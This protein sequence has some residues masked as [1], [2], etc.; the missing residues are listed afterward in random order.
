MLTL[1]SGIPV[2]IATIAPLAAVVL[3]GVA[4]IALHRRKLRDAASVWA[5]RTPM[6]D[7]DFLRAC[8]VPDEPFAVRAALSARRAIAALATVPAETIRPD[9]SFLDDLRR[10]PFWDSLDWLSFV[11]EVEK[12][13]NY[14]L[15]VMGTVAEGALKAAGDIKNLRVRHLIRS[16]MTAALSRPK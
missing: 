3:F 1:M 15:R 14:E 16:V 4:W 5:T 10:L 7:A 8:E 9:D 11:F 13:S 6:P 12:Q 2:F